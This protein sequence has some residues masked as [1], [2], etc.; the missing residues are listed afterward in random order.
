MKCTLL[1]R[2]TN[3]AHRWEQGDNKCKIAYASL[4]SWKNTTSISLG[5]WL[6]SNESYHQQWRTSTCGIAVQTWWYGENI[7]NL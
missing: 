2:D 1:L 3:D 6:T 7:P 5:I 4:S